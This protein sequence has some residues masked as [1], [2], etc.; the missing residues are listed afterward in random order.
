[1]NKSR[2]KHH[3]EEARKHIAEAEAELLIGGV[4]DDAPIETMDG[5]PPPQDPPPGDPGR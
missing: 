4:D 1:M 5:E 2:I 3:L